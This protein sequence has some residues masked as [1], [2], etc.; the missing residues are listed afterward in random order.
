MW[1]VIGPQFGGNPRDED[2]THAFLILS[3]TESTMILQTG[4]EI[5]EVDNSGFYTAGPTVFAGNM[6]N[7]K[8][9]VQVASK[10]VRLLRGL[11]QLQHIPIDVGS[12][13]VHASLSDPYLALLTADGQLLMITLR[14]V[15]GLGKIALTKPSISGVSFVFILAII[16][17]ITEFFNRIRE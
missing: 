11:D 1:T 8:Y 17:I 9:I 10:G 6:G 5:N 14:E 15:R 4:Q 2:Q 7:C 16:L 13:I 12:P 3:Q